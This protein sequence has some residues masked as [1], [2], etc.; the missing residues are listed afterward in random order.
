MIL[1][2]QGVV[3]AVQVWMRNNGFVDVEAV[4]VGRRGY[5]IQGVLASTGEHWLIEAKG[6]SHSGKDGSAAA[7]TGVGAAFLMTAGWRFEPD[8]AG[9]R[10]AIAVPNSFWFNRHVGRVEEALRVLGISVF[11]VTSLGEVAL[12]ENRPTATV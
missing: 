1:T 9:K 11:S 12:V 3:D 8:L 2:E 10:F 5:D 6:G 7:W 4:V